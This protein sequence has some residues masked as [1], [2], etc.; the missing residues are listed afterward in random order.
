MQGDTA[1]KRQILELLQRHR[2]WLTAIGILLV[3]NIICFAVIGLYQT[4]ALKREREESAERRKRLDA[5]ARGDVTAAYRNA[6]GDLKKLE[7]MIPPKR[8]FAAL[9][10]ELSDSA[11]QC[12]VS[13]DS[14]TYKPDFVKERKLI[15]YKITVSVHGRYSGVRCFLYEIQTRGD[16]VV[17]DSLSLKNDDAYVENVSMELLLTAYLRDGA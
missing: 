16:L 2:T 13:T 17:I 3:L 1:V 9:L 5:L 10:G 12:G 11:S 7:A 15:A 6:Q 4:P 14:I 8:S